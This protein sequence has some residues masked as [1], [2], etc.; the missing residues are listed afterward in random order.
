MGS[1]S[2]TDLKLYELH[3]C[4]RVPVAMLVRVTGS[5]TLWVADANGHAGELLHMVVV[6]AAAA[7]PSMTHAAVYV[8]SSSHAAAGVSVS[9]CCLAHGCWLSRC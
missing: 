1:V 9:R 5:P 3:F 8:P 4:L 2:L 7:M 6:E